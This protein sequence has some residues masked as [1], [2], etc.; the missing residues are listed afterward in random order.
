MSR[1]VS[2]ANENGQKPPDGDRLELLARIA[3]LYYEDRLTQEEVA[4][5]TGYSR[6]MISRFLTEARDL[7]VVEVKVNHPLGRRRELE[8]PLQSALGLKAVRV[9][10]RGTLDYSQ[11]MRRLGTLAARAVEELVQDNTIIGVSWG[12]GVWELTNALRPQHRAGVHI[13]QMMGA[14]AA[15]EP[16]TDGPELSRRLARIFSGR[17]TTLPMPLIVDSE[18]ISQSLR[19]DQRFKRVMMY[20]QDAQLALIG[21]GTVDPERSSMLRAGYLSDEQLQEL[22]DAG[23]V[24]DVCALHYN[25]HGELIDTPLTRRMVAIDA[26]TLKAIP[27]KLAVAGG[28]YKAATILGACRAGFI[29]ML[30]T[31]DVAAK[32]LNSMLQGDR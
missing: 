23:A 9:L 14:L 21:A 24:G 3:G 2:T 30:V 8:Q 4:Q 15:S 28:Q 29:D 25:L 19:E 32:S 17:Y 13:V 16:E 12:M 27:T 5:Q 7:N 1:R 6:S 31:D 10:S 18:A 20:C 22:R 11:M 26:T